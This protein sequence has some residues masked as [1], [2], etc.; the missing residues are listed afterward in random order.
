VE[1][2][3]VEKKQ[4]LKKAKENTIIMVDLLQSDFAETGITEQN[5]FTTN[6]TY[7]Y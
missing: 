7:S 3:K 6:E 5:K 2:T 1:R 4:W